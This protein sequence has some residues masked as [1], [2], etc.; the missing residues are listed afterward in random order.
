MAAA[1]A[2]REGKTPDAILSEQLGATPLGRM[3]EP[4][5]L[6]SVVAFLASERASYITGAVLAVDGG[7]LRSI[8]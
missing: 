8:D 3:G 7:R 2:Q 4:E 1:R 6:A 5:E